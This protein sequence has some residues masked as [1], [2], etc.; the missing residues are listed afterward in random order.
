MPQ[1]DGQTLPGVIGPLVS[2]ALAGLAVA[3]L[4]GVLSCGDSSGP[5]ELTPGPLANVVIIGGDDQQAV[6]GTELPQPLRVRAVDADDRPIP[7]QIVNFRVVAGGGSVFAGAALT[8]EDGVAQERWTLGTNT[9]EEQRLEVRAVDSDTGDPIVFGVF[10]ATALAANAQRL[11][12][13]TPPSTPVANR[14]PFSTQPAVQVEDAHGNP[15]GAGI[16]VTAFILSGGGTLAGATTAT[17]VSSG[18]ATFADLSISGLVGDRTLGFSAPGMTQV[19]AVVTVIP[20]TPA[21]MAP[22]AGA[23]QSTVIEAPVAT[24]PSVKITDADGNEISGVPVTFA[25]TSGGGSLTGP[26]QTTNSIGVA[27]VGSWTLGENA[28]ANTL[29]ATSPGVPGSPITFSATGL[30]FTVQSISA[31]GSHTCALTPSGKAYCWGMNDDGE[32][33]DGSAGGSRFTPTAVATSLTFRSIYAGGQHSCALTNA[34]AAYCWGRNSVGE[35]GDGAEGRRLLP[36]AVS[37]G[38]TFDTLTLGYYTTCGLTADGTAYCWGGSNGELG[39]GSWNFSRTPVPVSGGFKWSSLDA[40]DFHVCGIATTGGAYCW[41]RNG[42]G[43]MGNA[44]TSGENTPVPV[45]GG[46]AFASIFGEGDHTCALTSNGSAYCWGEWQ[47]PGYTNASTPTAVGG[48]VSFRV[49]DGSR[50]HTCGI[51]LNGTTYCWGNRAGALVDGTTTAY[52]TPTPISRPI[53]FQQLSV[54]AFHACGRTDAGVAY[55]WGENT[56]GQLGTPTEIDRSRPTPVTPP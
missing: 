45:S 51:G 34:G 6:V 2:H 41:G 8:N 18:V 46:I 48:G 56:R 7:G 27:A 22:N 9:S 17:T 13:V 43:Q 49:L 21:N 20:G 47:G 40:G 4:A 35:V 42:A 12:L 1:Q 15:V 54:G 14:T 5:G 31:A 19:S 37:G 44:S 29:T 26:N 11:A 23:N 10:R 39:N 25:I 24:A 32:V 55:C 50:Y 36:V 3:G 38:L 33:G 28:G 16:V 52:P 53:A 30:V